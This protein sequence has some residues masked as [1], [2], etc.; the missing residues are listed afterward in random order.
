MTLLSITSEAGRELREFTSATLKD[1]F[2][3][4]LGSVDF[5]VAPQ[6]SQW[7][8]FRQEFAKGNEVHVRVGKANLGRWII[9]EVKRKVS[10]KG[11]LTMH[12]HC[13][14]LLSAVYEAEIDPDFTVKGTSDTSV[15]PTFESVLRPYGFTEFLADQE[16]N[17]NA[18]AGEPI[19]GKTR[20]SAADL[21][22]INKRLKNLKSKKHVAQTGQSIYQFLTNI[23]TRL[24]V[25]MRVDGDG[26]VLLIAPNY[27][28][29]VG[30]FV[31]VSSRPGEQRSGIT[32]YFF[33]EITITDSNKGQFSEVSVVGQKAQ[34]DSNASRPKSGAVQAAAVLPPLCVYTSARHGHKPL[35]FKDKK[36]RD[37]K[38]ADNVAVLLLSAHAKDAYKISGKV[39]GWISKLGYV[40]TPGTMVAVNI[41]AEELDEPMYLLSRTLHLDAAGGMTTELEIIPKYALVLEKPDNEK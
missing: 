13:Q 23:I 35:F 17:L 6:R 27:D 18:M 16:A 5:E 24:G 38:A 2:T 20:P 37:K 39:H 31:G 9:Q 34:D 8:D 7:N 40:W 22:K 4:P 41:E 28:Q 1:S 29:E 26:R 11:G 30:F 33:G 10:D 15:L 3:D 21:D 25:V 19:G 12:L 32:D 14:S 36:S